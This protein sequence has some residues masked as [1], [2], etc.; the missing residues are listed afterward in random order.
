MTDAQ[1]REKLEFLQ[2]QAATARDHAALYGRLASP[3]EEPLR[4]AVLDGVRYAVQTSLQAMVDIAYALCAATWRTAPQDAE[5]AFG[6]LAAHRVING[7]RLALYRRMIGFRDRVLHG[8]QDPDAG[9]T[10]DYATRTADFAHFGAEI[11]AFV[12]SQPGEPLRTEPTPSDPSPDGRD[13][14]REGPGTS[15]A[16]PDPDALLAQLQERLAQVL[17]TLTE[18]EQD[19]LRLRFGMGGGEPHTLEETAQ[20][21]GVTRERVHQIERKILRKLLGDGGDGPGPDIA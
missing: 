12:S 15:G 13:A 21:F 2:R 1:I 6:Q 18:R 8:F 20:V 14:R 4:A 10:L 17:D 9:E 19:V 7:E 16:A 3:S 11:L 5:D